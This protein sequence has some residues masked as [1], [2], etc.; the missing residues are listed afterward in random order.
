MTSRGYDTQR[1]GRRVLVL[2]PA[3]SRVPTETLPLS[4]NTASVETSRPA[5]GKVPPAG[6]PR[7]QTLSNPERASATAGRSMELPACP[8][9][10]PPRRLCAASSIYYYNCHCTVGSPVDASSPRRSRPGAP[11]CQRSRRRSRPAPERS[12]HT[13]RGRTAQTP[14]KDDGAALCRTLAPQQDD[15]C[16]RGPCGWSARPLVLPL[17]C[18]RASD[19][20]KVVGIDGLWPLVR[21]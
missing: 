20:A 9:A 15:Y 12:P 5:Q 3:A 18:L 17:G 1:C 6:I 14:Q 8:T 16:R 13:G 21:C 4:S 2:P 19:V 10:F 11:P 7:A